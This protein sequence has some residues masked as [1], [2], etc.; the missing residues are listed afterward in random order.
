ME[1]D[2]SGSIV[3]ESLEMDHSP[4]SDYDGDEEEEDLEVKTKPSEEKDSSTTQV[5]ANEDNTITMPSIE[6]ARSPSEGNAT[7]GGSRY[8]S[9]MCKPL[10]KWW[11][12]HILPPRDVE[13][14]NV[15]MHDEPHTMSEAMQS[16][17]AKKW[18]LG[19]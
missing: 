4:E 17:D 8:P 15:V 6:Q 18:E 13:H 12:N 1:E 11:M 7:L 2:P 9:R 5:E 19:M 14:A 10:G 16:G 3:Q